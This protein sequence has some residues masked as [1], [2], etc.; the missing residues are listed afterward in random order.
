MKLNFMIII[1]LMTITMF[2]IKVIIG[3]EQI[4]LR[5]AAVIIIM[6]IKYLKAFNYRASSFTFVAITIDKILK[7]INSINSLEM[8]LYCYLLNHLVR[9]QGYLL[10]SVLEKLEVF[11]F[12]LTKNSID[13]S[14]L[15]VIIIRE[16]QG[17]RDGLCLEFMQSILIIIATIIIIAIA[18]ILRESCYL[19]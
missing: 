17:F 16:D 18:K 1:N 2:A 6:I 3:I 14:Y 4:K 5:E 10:N 15:I 13:L 9:Q 12:E 11:D 19:G 7:A 8:D